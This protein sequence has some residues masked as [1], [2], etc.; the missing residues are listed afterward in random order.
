MVVTVRPLAVRR[1][2]SHVGGRATVFTTQRQTLQ[3]TQSNQNDRGSHTNAG[4]ARQ[5]THDEGGQAHDQDGD[6]EGVFAADHVAQAAEED[7]AEGT[8][9]EAGREGQQ[10]KN[11]RGRGVEARKE[12]LG[13][14]RGQRSVEVEVI[15]LEHRAQ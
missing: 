1:V 11:E 14:D 7:G 6:Q 15:P 3:Q 2:F 9:N 4:I 12:L 5:H 13:N 8:N 10:R